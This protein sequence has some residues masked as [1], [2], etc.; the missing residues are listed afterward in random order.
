MNFGSLL[1]KPQ[2]PNRVAG[3]CDI[4]ITYR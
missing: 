1:K 3:E 4:T 2:I